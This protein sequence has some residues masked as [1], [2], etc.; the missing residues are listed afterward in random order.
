MS[1]WLAF[2]SPLALSRSLRGMLNSECG[3]GGS[4]GSGGHG[5]LGSGRG[6]PEREHPVPGGHRQVVARG[7]RDYD[8]PDVPNPEMPFDPRRP[9]GPHFNHPLLHWTEQSSWLWY[10]TTLGSLWLI[11]I[12][13]CAF[14]HRENARKPKLWENCSWNFFWIWWRIIDNCPCSKF[15]GSHRPN[16]PAI[17]LYFFSSCSSKFTQLLA[18]FVGNVGHILKWAF[19]PLGRKEPFLF[20]MENYLN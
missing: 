19:S 5:G 3:C 16:F 15:E 8:D 2:S 4:R 20:L 10:S 14:V 7:N 9:A 17:Y 11:F 12:R 6:Q 18:V 13:L 1:W